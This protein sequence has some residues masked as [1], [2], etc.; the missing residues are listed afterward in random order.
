MTGTPTNA[1]IARRLKEI[2]SLMEFAGEP[3][4]KFMAY[5]RAAEAV[6]N[7][8]PVA[9]LA[10]AGRLQE[11]PGIGK[12]IA[13]RIAELC[14]T[15]ACAYLDELQARYP[16]TLL[17]VL[18]VPGVGMKT[19]QLLY[20]RLG[21]ASLD[22][23]QR[24]IDA[25]AL[26][27]VPRLGA[28]SIEN[29]KRGVLSAK[30]RAHRT[31]LGIAA[32]RADEIVAYLAERTP[33][34]DLTPAGSLR[35]QEATVGDIDIVCTSSEP[36]AVIAAF[37][38][39]PEAEAVLAE[40]GTKASIWLPGALQIDLRVLPAHLYGNLLQHFTGSREHNIQL[41]EFAVRKNLRV[42]E[43]GIVDLADGR[44]ITCRTEAEVYATLG[45]A[46]IPPEM[47]VGLGEL[48]AARSGT[49]P[50]VVGLGDL[51]GDLHVHLAG[52]T[53]LEDLAQAASARGYEYLAVVG[54]TPDEAQ[55]VGERFGVRLFC[56]A[57]V[58][59]RADGS[60]AAPD[61]L[62]ARQDFVIASVRADL[63]L[64]PD[65][66][67]RRLVRACENPYL[68]LITHLTGR[69]VGGDPGYA[70]DHDAVFAAAARTGTAL[71][72][73]GRPDRLDLPGSL[74][75]QAKEFGVTLA[76]C[77]GGVAAA[78][79]DHVRFAIGQ[80][81]RGWVT[82]AEV[83]N[84]RPAAGVLAFTTVKRRAASHAAGRSADPG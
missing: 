56:A 15:G 29:I 73:D 9:A 25:G 80:A 63:D 38:A 43:N 60:L 55:R 16:L 18:E 30:S 1:E 31:P 68:N 64:P 59:I 75:R 34:T 40:G 52:G 24:A 46:E 13:G 61:E 23:L 48:E 45:M 19:A 66:M 12:T 54:A 11:V 62:L 44:L 33:A 81:R 76:C 20:E 2:R 50:P 39:F 37:T 82:A 49:L 7:A 35:R 6:E 36:D 41:R 77:S 51:R 84:A 4:F 71:D 58:G 78:D 83:L 42:S 74:A 10:A 65:E 27:D 53:S 21:V 57:D 3:Y 79:F 22:D 47:R 5:E 72:I 14:A 8:P 70:F 17:E 26:A 69:R 28:K 67:T 32:A